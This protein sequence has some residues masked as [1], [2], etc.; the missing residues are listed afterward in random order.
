MPA[1]YLG[2]RGSSPGKFLKFYFDVGVFGAFFGS[3]HVVTLSDDRPE[4]TPVDPPVQK[5]GGLDPVGRWMRL[6]LVS[7][8]PEVLP[9]KFY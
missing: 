6:C 4:G 1:W 3:R 7:G 5:S 8:G 2:A 9:R